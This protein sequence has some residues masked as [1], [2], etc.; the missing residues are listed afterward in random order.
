MCFSATASFGTTVVLTAIGIAS[1]KKASTRRA[2]PFAAIPI[3]FAIQQFS[4][5]MLWI[6]LADPVH[7]WWRRFPVYFFLVFAQLIWPMWVPFAVTLLEKNPVR[8]RILA[9]FL[10]MG[11]SISAYLLYCLVIYEISA[12]IESG[13]I[14]YTLNFPFTLSWFTGI[15]YFIP[16][17]VTLFV[18]SA[19]RMIFLAVPVLLSFVL[20]KVFFEDHL[21]SVWCFFAAILSMIILAIT[22]KFNDEAEPEALVS[23][24][25]LPAW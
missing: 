22:S 7:D 23:K 17:V 24:P 4:E 2:I 21:I 12:Q 6:A 11:L 18:S 8:R 25:G 16:T 15:L 20:A 1:L 19:K 9:V 13:H 10:L 3:M 5:G 14:R